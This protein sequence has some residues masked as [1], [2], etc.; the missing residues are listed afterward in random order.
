MAIVNIRDIPNLSDYIDKLITID[1]QI[2]IGI[3]ELNDVFIKKFLDVGYSGVQF[4]PSYVLNVSSN[5]KIGNNI[6]V[7]NNLNVMN[8]GFMNNITAYNLDNTQYQLLTTSESISIY[9]YIDQVYN[10]YIA[11]S[12]NNSVLYPNVNSL[13]YI[14][15]NNYDPLDIFTKNVYKYNN[16]NIQNKFDYTSS[17]IT[18]TLAFYLVF[19]SNDIYNIDTISSSL[20]YKINTIE[21]NN[22]GLYPV[23]LI[24]T[25]ETKVLNNN[26]CTII[27]LLSSYKN[28][29][30]YIFGININD[31]IYY[32]DISSNSL[33][34]NDISNNKIT[35]IYRN[36]LNDIYS[37]ITSQKIISDIKINSFN[38][39][40]NVLYTNGD[41][42]IDG[43][44]YIT[45]NA[46]FMNYMNVSNDAS[47]NSNVYVTGLT[48]I[49]DTLNVSNDA[50]FNSSVFVKGSTKLLD[51]LTVLKNASFNSSV[52]VTGTTTLADTLTVSNDASFNS[53]VFVKG[54]TNLLDTLTVLKNASFN[55][56]VYVTGTTTLA[57]TLN[58]SNDASFNS[59]VYVSGDLK[60]NGNLYMKNAS[61]INTTTITE[62]II[63]NSETITIKNQGETTA[64]IINQISTNTNDIVNFQENSVTVFRIGEYGS[65]WV[66]DNLYVGSIINNTEYTLDVSGDAYFSKNIN[67]SGEAYFS[68]DI[69]LTGNVI[70]YSDKR[71]KSNIKK[72]DSCLEKIQ[73]INGYTYNRLDINNDKVHIGLI[74]QEIEEIFPELVMEANNIKGI[75]YQG[76]IA[77]L[78]NCIKEL[79]EKINDLNKINK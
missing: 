62:T 29:S 14:Y 58:V 28:N 36:V 17:S 13:N 61:F 75:N 51:T 59:N 21:K 34:I 38:S 57:D 68:K 64:L 2:S 52:Y 60:L 33:V 8:N 69:T 9:I 53:S 18:N 77:I 46:Y 26:N 24:H 70:S 15:D 54:A 78:L 45:K 6:D 49:S 11:L 16:Y 42:T 31:I 47:F 39:S 76:F 67:V 43:N 79:N 40:N 5:A 37:P 65:A 41:A 1:T 10:V 74:A 32:Y 56:S 12:L 55:S 7:Y 25:Y 20:E 35:P 63:K 71:I 73:N 22:I 50:S 3:I 27:K 72:V 23:T 66:A 48:K 4:D 19:N 30:I 44:S